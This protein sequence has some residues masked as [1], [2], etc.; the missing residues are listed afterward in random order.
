MA[1]NKEFE[2]LI[3]KRKD[4][5]RASKENKFDFDSLLA[6]LYND[7]SHFIYEI[8][9]NAEDEGAKEVRFELFEDRLDVYHNGKDFDL[10]D[11]DGVTG[12]GI[13]KKKDDLT[14][15]GKF[16]VGFKSV[17]AITETPYI[18]SGEYN[19]KIEDFVIPSEV[20]NKEQI[21][22]TLIRLPFNH[23]LR[24]PKEVFTLVSKKL[25]NIGLKTM[26]FLKN[27]EEIKWQTPS[28]S[29]HCLK[30]SE[31][32]QTI[33]DAKRVTIISSSVS[34]E[35]IVIGKTIKIEGKDLK[36]EVAYKL[37]KDK[38]G[39]ETIIPE[40]DSQLV[41]Y[42]PTEKVTYLNFV[43]QGPYK[44]TPNRENIP[45]EDK[46]NKAILEETANL[47]AESLSIIKDLGYLDTNFL[48]LL[49]INSENK[50]KELIYSVIYD[51]VKNKFFT[52]E[53][54]PTSDRKYTKASDALL[55]RGKE[56]T[57]FL[58][59]N[60]IQ[61]LFSKQ[62]WLDTNITYD[63][64]RE[65]RDYLTN[66]LEVVEV[67]F[68]SFA[69]KV[70]VEF[71]QTKSHEW[72]IDFYSRLLNQQT[73]WSD[74]E[75][76]KGILRTKPI[77][78][79]ENG[80][81]I[82]PFDDNGKVQV[83]LPTETKSEYKTVKRIFTEN[84]NS[85]KF[86]TELRLTKPDLFA[87][88][89][90]CII[91]KYQIDNPAKDEWYLEDF[92]KL[93]KAYETI[94]A[95]KKREFIGELSE[96]SFIDSVKKDTGE[97]HLRKPA[98]T[99]F[100]DSDLKDYFDGYNSVYFIADGLYERFGEERLKSF[101]I[102]LDVEDKPRRVEIAGNLTWEEKKILRGDIQHTG[103]VYQ[104]DC[105]YEG[106]E[107]FIKQMTTSKSYL[108]WRL[109]LR[110]IENSKPR[111][112]KA[113]F[114]GKYRWWRYGDHYEKGFD[115]KFLKTLKQ[116]AWLVD[117]N[118]IFR[119]PSDIT[120][121]ELSDN[122]IKES[123]NIDILTK[124]LEFKPEIIDQLPPDYRRILEIVKGSGLSPEELE[125][126]LSK[127]K[128]EHSGKE[129]KTWTP[130]HEPDTVDV[131][132]K[133]V[134]PDII[135]TPDLTGQGEQIDSEENKEP[136]EDDKKIEA[137]VPKTL[138]DKKAIGKWGEKYVYYALKEKYQEQGDIIETDSGFKV[139]N[140][141]DE[142]FEIIWMNKYQDRGRGY[143]FVIRKNETE[144][145]YI[146]VKSKTREDEELIEVT[147]TQWEF[148]RK[149]YEQNE[150]EKYS[151]Y[152]VLNTGK[153]NAQIHILKNPVKLW[154][155]GKIYAH[156]VN[157]KL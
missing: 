115:A 140:A 151:F 44:T 157:F 61:K 93:L 144:I 49:P 11:I 43:I 131:K 103:D 117:K 48:S 150:G 7:P 67:D 136:T 90:E 133:E 99:Y 122:Y 76:S 71:L 6:G 156:P 111:E 147:G 127:S 98:E 84:E 153:E 142:E 101:L 97:N 46:Q 135:V 85:S 30:S 38:N 143:D 78:R 149:L 19:I 66:E 27:I 14:S 18:F 79:L 83:Y 56:L 23:K 110:N 60:D 102:D 106:L 123:P 10:E 52:E 24:S 108:L 36:V 86:L 107:N 134:K 39:K 81:H 32:F 34:E 139:I 53:L 54:L 62:Y 118:N 146:E 59:S 145:G 3:E 73:L 116:Q 4:W 33:P 12:I 87:E 100:N 50:K 82:A 68:E 42:F 105:E 154:K 45:L 65:L 126:L 92:G 89:K 51:K 22:G 141:G 129:E 15:I 113:F 88:I 80:E 121:S 148:A 63:K 96:A 55:A 74:R 91:P 132:I 1:N 138:P 64:T 130:E 109:L 125:K 29:G 152:V 155:E 41:V 35:Y 40:V 114:E 77:I 25:E 69:R 57:D 137:D 120:F 16:G 28:T 26:L 17:F 20:S 2:K 104:K 13:S 5:V 70:T 72:M 124:A 58:D 37:G 119:K 94:P 75:Y 95:N 8:L 128:E 21:N 31:S 9:Q 47:V 112:A